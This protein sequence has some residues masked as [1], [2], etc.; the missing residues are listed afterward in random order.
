[1]L[2]SVI[3]PCRF[4][5]QPLNVMLK[6]GLGV[7]LNCNI[8]NSELLSSRP[9]HHGFM[10]LDALFIR[11]CDGQREGFSWP[12]GQ[13]TRESPAGTRQVP[14]GPLAVKWP[15]VVRDSALHGE[16]AEGSNREGHRD[17]AGRH[18]LGGLLRKAQEPS[19]G[20]GGI[21]VVGLP[22]HDLLLDLV[23]GGLGDDLSVLLLTGV[24]TTMWHGEISGFLLSENFPLC[25]EP[26]I[27]G[28]LVDTSLV[29]LVGASR[30]LLMETFR[31]RRYLRVWFRL[32]GGSLA[33]CLRCGRWLR[34]HGFSP[35]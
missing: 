13:I 14:H 11:K 1:M 32:A 28:P 22:R 15:R 3:A 20:N 12:H 35:M 8:L 6:S 16:A 26:V 25:Q 29:N 33:R 31:H 10:D 5:H 17:L 27:Q 19:G 7:S 18:I 4:L 21:S 9:P 34:F 30:D 24:S 23:R 2:S